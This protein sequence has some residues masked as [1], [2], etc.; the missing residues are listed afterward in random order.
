[1]WLQKRPQQ[2]SDVQLS[3][4]TVF[5]HS[6]GCWHCNPIV[7][8]QG[9]L[10]FGQGPLTYCLFLQVKTLLMNGEAANVNSSEIWSKDKQCLSMLSLKCHLQW[11]TVE[12]SCIH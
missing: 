1:M 3:S 2:T 4:L 10:V 9:H 5:I 8:G 7:G 12:L 11:T 6:Y